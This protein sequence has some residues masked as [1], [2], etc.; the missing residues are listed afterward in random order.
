M[1]P[2]I[3]NLSSGLMALFL[4]VLI[5]ASTTTPVFA[6]KA[7]PFPETTVR[8][9]SDEAS[10]GAPRWLI[11]ELDGG[12][13]GVEFY[14][15]SLEIKP[16]RAGGQMWQT[17]EIQG[18]VLNGSEGRPGLPVLGRLVAVPAGK[19]L[20]VELL[21]FKKTT[22]DKLDILPVQD[23]SDESFSL[24]AAAYRKSPDSGADRPDILVG[25]PAI[26]AGQT[27]V[28]LTL[29][30][31]TYDPVSRKAV[32]WTEVRL[33]LTFV[34]DPEAPVKSRSRSG[35]VASS[36]AT[37]LEN[38]ALG[39]QYLQQSNGKTAGNSDAGLGTYAAVYSGN[40]IVTAGIAPMLE[41]RRQQGYHLVV[42]NT[43]ESGN[44]TSAIKNALRDIYEDETI[45]PLEFISI[46]GDVDGSFGVP[47]W[48]EN[49]SGY[50]GGGDHYYTTLDG[51]DILADVHIGRVSFRTQTEMDTVIG[52]ILGYEKTPPMDDTSWFERAYVQGD[53]NDSGI[54]TIYVNQWLKGQFLAQ[55]WTQVD[56]TWSGSF[57][58][59]LMTNVGRGVSAYGYRGFYG[60]S[61]IT[62]GHVMALSNGGKIPM[63]LLPTCGS[64]NFATEPTS[65]SEAWLR[66]PNGGAVAAIGT[67]TSGTHTRY[68]NCYY[69]GAWDGLLNGGDYRIGAGHTLGK[70]ALYNGYFLAEPD[71]SEIWAVWNNIMGDPATEM[72]TGVPMNLDVDYP[73]H[74]SLGAHAIS[75]S[76]QHT[77]HP[78]SGARVSLYRNAGDIL[79]TGLTDADGRVLLDLPA[80]EAGSLAVTVTGHNLLP[81]LGGLTVGQVDVFCAATGRTIDHDFHPGATIQVTPRL[82]NHGSTDAFSVSAELTVQTGPATVSSGSLSFGTIS[83]GAEVS[84]TGPATIQLADDARDGDTINLLLTVTNGSET[85]T[86]LLRETVQAADFNVSEFHLADFGGSLDPG[87]S[88]RFD[89][90]LK[91]LGA[92][93]ATAV[94]AILSSDSPWIVISDD[95]ADFGNIASGATGRDLSSPF[96]LSISTD[97]FGGHLATF[98]LAVTYSNGMQSIVHCAVTIGSAASDQP[99]GPDAY[100]YYAFDNTDTGSNM[101]PTYEW[102]GIDPDHGAQ[103][104]DLGLTDFGW[105]QDDTKSM[106][107]PFDFG[108]YGTSYNRIS[109]CSNGWLAMGD[110]PVNFYRN[111]ALPAPHSAGA[112]IAPFWDN[113]NQSGNH[114]VYTWNDTQNHRFIIQWYNMPNHFSGAIQNFEVI[115]LDPAHHPTSSGEGMILFQYEQ[116]NNTDGR[117]GFATVGIQNLERTTGVNYGYWNQYAPGAAPLVSGRAILFLPM[118]EIL[119][120]VAAVSPAAM[121]QSLAPNAQG[122]QYLHIANNGAEGSVLNF[123]LDKVDPAT[124]P[125]GKIEVDDSDLVFETRNVT[126]SEVTTTVTGFETGSTINLPFSVHAV[127][128]DGEFL[129]IV[130]LDLPEGVTVNS[131]TNIPTQYG[132][133]NWNQQIGD[134]AVTSWGDPQSGWAMI[135]PGETVEGSVN[136]SISSSFSG[137]MVIGWTLQ[138]ENF[139]SPPHS[140]SGELVLS[141]LG[142]A[143]TVSEPTEG[144]VAVIG[145]E[146]EVAFIATNGPTQIDIA[147]QRE[148]GGSWETLAT[149]LAVDSSPWSWSV[150]GEPGPYARIRVS[151]SSDASVFDLSGV[152]KVSRN[153]DWLQP[154]STSGHILVGQTFD[155]EL[156]LDA[157]GLAAGQYVANLLVSSNG[158][159][160]AVVPVT[161]AVGVVT[162][163]TE[164]PGSLALLGNYPNP[165]N[166]QTVIS[167][168]L[169]SAQNVTLRVY[170]ARGRLVRSL[171]QGS[172]P[173]GIHHTVWDG[174]DEQGRG[175]ASGVYF[176]RLETGNGNFTG[177]MVLA[178]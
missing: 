55:G 20:S 119:L 160:Q 144:S 171:L 109:I 94:S 100:G 115:L 175:A 156:T 9:F 148:E 14:L 174:R 162:P 74:I 45:P 68:N 63:A 79:V 97:C 25:R 33:R 40:A 90:S 112:L 151:D 42:V 65:R 127:S 169:P 34:P 157:T 61:G 81:H 24:S 129:S 31:V 64:G 72:W 142:P 58:N 12:A 26:M 2:R 16:V 5:I 32:V 4:L 107:L 117:D 76:V 22:L 138:G 104:V 7:G 178:K 153:L 116:V 158:G 39:F 132:P 1:R 163:V 145:D 48:H 135:F 10:D 78:M 62:N 152:F 170:S 125:A 84:A 59:S 149:N 18:S 43:A 123:N 124:M 147:L 23:P 8:V 11:E 30:P 54:T 99:T 36:F 13:M 83:S 131:A 92:L 167:F 3:I 27:V 111:Y 105:E 91:N 44:N 103:G 177:K 85:W 165:F 161:L 93:D 51:D 88:G 137:D 172:Q 37:Q 49:L 168:S 70:V 80:L 164:T 141:P 176:Y 69:V 114:R 108:F 75:I 57:I 95:R 150:V 126:G 96:F 6:A 166:P 101:A 71:V 66:A 136:L 28:P 47:T 41:W 146:L 17:L 38:Q 173:A 98:E 50:N 140:V 113:L 29:K 86:S 19:A 159:P 110:T 155:L 106:D 143:I 128:S 118:G 89:L 52:K 67:S 21:S 139:G 130:T 46:F 134:G 56:T 35:L 154:A 73:A 15:P 53:P 120:P 102:V 82:T 77:G 87:E 60:T 122:T 133:M 121:T